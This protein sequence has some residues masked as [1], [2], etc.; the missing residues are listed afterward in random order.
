[1]N[2]EELTILLMPQ[3]TLHCSCLEHCFLFVVRDCCSVFFSGRSGIRTYTGVGLLAASSFTFCM[4]GGFGEGLQDLTRVGQPVVCLLSLDSGS[5]GEYV[6][7][8]QCELWPACRPCITCVSV[9][10]PRPSQPPCPGALPF[11]P[12]PA[13]SNRPTRSELLWTLRDH[14]QWRCGER[15]RK[16]HVFE[17]RVRVTCSRP[18]PKTGTAFVSEK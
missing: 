13:H 18:V 4:L 3:G 7:L 6:D 2:K 9:V 10:R 8:V 17:S 5:T 16:T 11:Q 14:E 12:L 1:M 15:P